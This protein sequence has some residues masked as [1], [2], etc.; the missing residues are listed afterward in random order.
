M[1]MR[2]KGALELS[3]NAIVILILAITMLGLGLGFMKKT[4]GGVTEQ[5]GEVSD[6]MRKDMT[7]RLKESGKKIDVDANIFD[8]KTSDQKTVYL[9]VKNDY[10]SA[11]KF[12]ICTEDNGAATGCTLPTGQTLDCQHIDDSATCDSISIETVK[13]M[14]IEDGE[15]AVIPVLVKVDSNAVRTTFIFKVAA[16]PQTTGAGESAVI[17]LFITVT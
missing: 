10:D 11:Q 2:K 16:E 1:R 5:F 13:D 8:M 9:A 6:Q 15:V 4:F 14:F 12:D 7:E 17:D 3:I